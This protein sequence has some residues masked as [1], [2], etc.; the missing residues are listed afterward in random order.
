[1]TNRPGNRPIERTVHPSLVRPELTLGVERHVAGIE[2]TICFALLCS[3]GIG[4]ATLGFVALV[5][6][7]IHPVM[8]WLTA[9]DEQATQVF[10]RSRRY[11]DFYAPHGLHKA[12]VRAPRPSIPRVR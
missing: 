2:A 7:A 1:M 5:I 4:L 10:A 11:A 12:N 9:K 8:V 3:R 6:I